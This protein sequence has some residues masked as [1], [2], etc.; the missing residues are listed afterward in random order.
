[1]GD[2]DTNGVK[3][4]RAERAVAARVEEKQAVRARAASGAA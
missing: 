3:V 2:P 4:T 1:M